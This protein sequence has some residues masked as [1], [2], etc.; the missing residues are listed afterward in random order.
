MFDIVFPGT[1][2]DGG[3][4][5][6]EPL[7][8]S[9]WLKTFKDGTVVECIVRRPSKQKS[10]RQQ[11]YYRGYVCQTIGQHLG[12]TAEEMHGIIQAAFFT[13]QKDDGTPYIRSTALSGWTTKEWEEKI[14]EIIRW[15]AEEF[16]V[17]LLRPDEV[18]VTS[19]Y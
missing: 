18:D 13:Y 3:F 8:Y 4:V 6:S 2:R 1:V 7:R 14:E 5:P 16:G 12:Y 10:N 11:R 15:S 19:Q 17:V 9:R